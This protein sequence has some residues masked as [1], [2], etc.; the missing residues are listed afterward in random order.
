MP[1]G[2]VGRRCRGRDIQV[3]IVASIIAAHFGGRNGRCKVIIVYLLVLL[4]AL[5]DIGGDGMDDI[6]E[7]LVAIL[8]RVRQSTA[9]MS[10]DVHLVIAPSSSIA[11]SDRIISLCRRCG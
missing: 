9:D 4:D 8:F 10:L 7:L 3:S 1:A 5:L 2:C 6:L 11:P